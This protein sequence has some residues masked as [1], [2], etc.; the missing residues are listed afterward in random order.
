MRA[1]A[2][3]PHSQ[4]GAPTGTR[5]RVVDPPPP[6][7]GECVLTYFPAST[8]IFY[9]LYFPVFPC[10]VLAERCVRRLEPWVEQAS[11][12]LFHSGWRC[13][14]SRP[15]AEPGSCPPTQPLADASS[16]VWCTAR[17][18]PPSAAHGPGAAQG[19]PRAALGHA[20][21][22]RRAQPATIPASIFARSM[23]YVRVPYFNVFY[24]FAC[25][26]LCV[27]FHVYVSALPTSCWL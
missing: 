26:L 23:L 1:H 13:A 8:Y 14:T 24:I 17:A 12:R 9:V 2:G 18:E 3:M 11:T 21:F 16:R 5:P 27:P 7:P 15:L 20:G 10:G 22:L 6:P 25:S 4:R 19:A